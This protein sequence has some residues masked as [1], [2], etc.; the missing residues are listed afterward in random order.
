MTTPNNQSSRRVLFYGDSN[1]YGLDP[2][3]GRGS[4]GRYPAET[5][6]PDILAEKLQ[7]SWEILV[8]AKPGRCIPEMDFEW[9]EWKDSIC[10][11]TPLDLFAVMLGTNDYLSAAHPD[12]AS[13]A[14][15]ME[16]FITGALSDDEACMQ[17]TQFLVI[18]PPYLDFGDDRFYRPYNTT[19]GVLSRALSVSAQKAGAAFLDAGAWE[20]PL[21]PD[22]IHL[23]TGGH[24]KLACHMFRYMAERY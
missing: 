17:E 6:W 19:S 2:E 9:C 20:L 12:A 22:G 10:R 11:N 18:A 13:V 1:T 23:S 15:K 7:G 14:D 8:D 21:A 16:R 3:S 4:G 24:K 5:R